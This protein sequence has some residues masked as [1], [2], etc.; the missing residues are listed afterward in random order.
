MDIARP[1]IARAKK[2]RRILYSTAFA[3]V[4]IMVT[5]GVS[6]LEPAAPRVERDTVFMDT[7]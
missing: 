1:D 4:L 3:V 5:V 6:R 2:V 7:V